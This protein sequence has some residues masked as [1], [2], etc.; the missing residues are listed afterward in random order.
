MLNYFEWEFQNPILISMLQ[1]ALR[2][3]SN[4]FFKEDLCNLKNKIYTFFLLLG[5]SILK[6]NYFCNCR[7]SI[8]EI[9]SCSIHLNLLSNATGMT[10]F[11]YFNT[12]LC[13]IS[14]NDLIMVWLSRAHLYGVPRLTISSF[15]YEIDIQETKVHL[16]AATFYRIPIRY[17]ERYLWRF[18][19]CHLFEMKFGSLKKP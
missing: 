18:S 6:L 15:S 14:H 17:S 3:T 8:S 11:G 9:W 7:P 16:I 4:W 1:Y 10:W 19:Q 2:I 5:S 13:R 12:K